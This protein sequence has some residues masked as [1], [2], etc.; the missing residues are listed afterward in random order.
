MRTDQAVLLTRNGPS[1]NRRI[2]GPFAEFLRRSIGPYKGAVAAGTVVFVVMVT[3]F[4]VHAIS[5]RSVGSWVFFVL[6]GFTRT[7]LGH[8][9][10]RIAATTDAFVR[11]MPTTA[12]GRVDQQHKDHD[13]RNRELHS[14]LQAGGRPP[15]V[16][17]VPGANSHASWSRP[18]IAPTDSL[19][20]TI[21]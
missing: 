13:V 16:C 9:R 11:M 14:Q 5:V 15:L 6:M 3:A 10:P 1:E 7:R 4:G 20:S 17:S 21:A 18:L 12:Q 2:G 19:L 8:L